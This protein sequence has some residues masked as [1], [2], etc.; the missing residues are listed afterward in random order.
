MAPQY[1]HIIV[2]LSSY[3]LS[4]TES[5]LA[6]GTINVIFLKKKH[7]I[8]C[9]EESRVDSWKIGCK[10]VKYI[11]GEPARKCEDLYVCTAHKKEWSPTKQSLLNREKKVFFYRKMENRIFVPA[12]STFCFPP[13][14]TQPP[15]PSCQQN[16]NFLS[17]SYFKQTSQVTSHSP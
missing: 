10:N 7:T 1:Y 14:L 3:R 6:M 13:P 16:T 11:E 15:G 9:V 8:F 4:Q 17:A 5:F 2:T 12:V